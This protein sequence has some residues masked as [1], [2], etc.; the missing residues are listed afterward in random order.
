MVCSYKGAI[1]VDFISRIFLKKRENSEILSTR[2]F[3]HVLKVKH[4]TAHIYNLQAALL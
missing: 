3:V 2:N 4:K 1:C